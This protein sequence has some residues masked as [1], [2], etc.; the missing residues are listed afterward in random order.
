MARTG[1]ILDIGNDITLGMAAG[2]SVVSEVHR[3]ARIRPL[4][5]HPIDTSAAVQL[6]GPGTTFQP[7]SP[8]VPFQSVV[9]LVTL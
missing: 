8:G 4:V 2:N 7:V 3:H 9:T 5:G 1:D 6:V